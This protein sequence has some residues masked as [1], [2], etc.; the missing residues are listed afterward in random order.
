MNTMLAFAMGEANRDRERKVFD[1][2]KAAQRIKEVKPKEAY[3]GLEED[4]EWTGGIIYRNGKIVNQDE[5]C[6]YLAST[7]AKPILIMDFDEEECWIMESKTEFDEDTYWPES[8]RKILEEN[9][10]DQV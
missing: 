7:W 4:W 2:N 5:T 10:D 8:A 1:W 9:S 3:A 6:T